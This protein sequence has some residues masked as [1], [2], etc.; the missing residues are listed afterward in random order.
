[1][2]TKKIT[3]AERHEQRCVAEDR[4]ERG[5]FGDEVMKLRAAKASQAEIAEWLQQYLGQKHQRARRRERWRRAANARDTLK[6]ILDQAQPLKRPHSELMEKWR[7]QLRAGKIKPIEVQTSRGPVELPPWSSF[8]EEDFA[9]IDALASS[10]KVVV[11]ALLRYEALTHADHGNAVFPRFPLD[12]LVLV[13][14]IALNIS[15]TVETMTKVRERAPFR[16]A[17]EPRSADARRRAKEYRETFRDLGL[18]DCK[19]HPAAIAVQKTLKRRKKNPQSI[20]T[21]KRTLRSLEMFR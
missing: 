10:L 1:M 19:L 14:S 11:E 20:P 18:G 3:C 6:H 21:I 8:P 2:V 5:R 12:E 17:N 16:D 13:L 15:P 9:D 7:R 4:E